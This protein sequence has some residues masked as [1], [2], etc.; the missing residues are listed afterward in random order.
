VAV[1]PASGPQGR[2]T[3][4]DVARLAGVH[5]GTAS[6]ALRADTSHL[7]NEETRGNVTRA[8]EMLGFETNPIARGLRTSRSY[9]I[10]V[11]IPDIN[12]PLFPPIVR[13]IEDTVEQQGYTPLLA[14][15]DNDPRRESKIINAMLARQVDGL[16]LATASED[17]ATMSLLERINVPVVFANRRSGDDRLPS[18][19]VDD[20]GGIRLVVSHLRDLGHRDIAT[21]AGPSNLSTGAA[22]RR[23]FVE[24]M[25]DVGLDLNDRR[26]ATA[27][28][29]T[30]DEGRE[31]TARLLA[32]PAPPTA[33]VAANDLLALGAYDA[34]EAAGLA[35]PDLV[36]VTGFN[37]MPFADRFRPPLTTVRIPQI[38]IGRAAARSLL[39]GLGSDPPPPTHVVLDTELIVRGSTAP[40]P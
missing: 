33:I 15:T 32:G 2:A 19:T 39:Q 16:I 20:L 25:K 5:P 3:L 26:I 1:N 37:D 22:R 17:D 6:K 21:V 12:N 13:G 35:C 30:E 40:P 18:V 11:L 36:S 23:G 28:A 27:G 34:L 8:A 4:K 29:F 31:A 24:A 7:V 14:N 9:T 38:E 10:G